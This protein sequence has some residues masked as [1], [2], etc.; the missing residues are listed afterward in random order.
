[1]SL[2]ML[3]CLLLLSGSVAAENTVRIEAASGPVYVNW[4]QPDELP[5]ARDYRVQVEDFD[6]NGDGR[7]S[8]SELPPGHALHAEWKLV[9][10]NRDGAIT[11]AELAA[12]K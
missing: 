7:L 1:M 12:W 8:H 2:R 10:R 5:N 11:A 3:F 6:A 9:D 4:G